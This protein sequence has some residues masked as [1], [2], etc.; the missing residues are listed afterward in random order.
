MCKFI[1][2][3]IYPYFVDA[4]SI[5]SIIGLIAAFCSQQYAVIIALITFCVVLL[6]MLIGVFVAINKFIK[7]NHNDAYKKVSSFYIYR[8]DDGIKSTF[9][10]YRLIQCKRPILSE[11]EYKYK[12]SGT[13]L[14][15]LTSDKQIVEQLP[16]NNDPNIWDKAIIKFPTPLSYNESTVLHIRTEND[17]YDKKA[18]PWIECCLSSPIEIMQFR[19][20]LA[21]K[22]KN[23]SKKAFLKRR[24]LGAEV[25]VDYDIIETVDFDSK[26]KQYNHIVL[27]PEP[28]YSYRLEWE[29]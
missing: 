22:A 4:A 16:P 27:N 12:W 1:K 20:L 9:E 3:Y 24:K 25:G 19:V 29:K 23:Y 18:K 10:T 8:S 21:Y 15:K 14:P 6:L 7:S 28:G 5:A 13:K 2:R 17:D 26:Y 11:I